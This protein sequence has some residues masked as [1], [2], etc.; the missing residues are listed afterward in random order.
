MNLRPGTTDKEVSRMVTERDG[1]KLGTK[2]RS[3][4]YDNLDGT[5]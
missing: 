4:L 1:T 5:S 3:V 2:Y